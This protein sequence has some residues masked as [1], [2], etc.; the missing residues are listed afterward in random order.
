MFFLF[1]TITE[2]TT[3]VGSATGIPAEESDWGLIKETLLS[4]WECFF[5][6]KAFTEPNDRS[7]GSAA[8]IP[9][10]ESDWGLI[11]ETLLSNW[12]CFLFYGVYRTNDH[13]WFFREL[14]Q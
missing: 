12:E 6:F 13:R 11:R 1:K 9:T 7:F 10:E 14:D 3:I 2:P 5:Y 8:G 4:N